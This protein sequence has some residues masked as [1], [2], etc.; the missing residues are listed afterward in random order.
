MKWARR[1]RAAAPRQHVD[2]IGLAMA[3]RHRP[4][5]VAPTG[6]PLGTGRQHSPLASVLGLRPLAIA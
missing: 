1:H 6:P 4:V 2:A 5:A 3:Q